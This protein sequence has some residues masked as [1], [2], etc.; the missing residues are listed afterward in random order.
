[1]STKQSTERFQG[2]VLKRE[3]K[4]PDSKVPMTLEEV[5]GR[6]APATFKKAAPGHAPGPGPNP[7]GKVRRPGHAPSPAVNPS[8]KRK[9]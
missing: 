5:V 2:V 3:T 6:I 9:T 1:M 4:I 7:S 8:G